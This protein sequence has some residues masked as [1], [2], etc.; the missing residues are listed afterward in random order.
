MLLAR[1][2]AWSKPKQI[3]LAAGLG[4][5]LV[6]ALVWW[7]LGEAAYL[8]LVF[9][10]PSSG[11]CERHLNRA[12]LERSLALGTRFLLAHQ[13]PAGNFDYEYDWRT[14]SLSE[15]D[16][17]VRQA[18]ALW[19]LTLL[20]QDAPKP[21]LAAGIERALAFFH[22]HS[23]LA[24]G[25]RC[26]A[27]PG[28]ES[29][30][31]GTVALVTLAHV[32][33]LRAAQELPSAHRAAL[34]QRLGEYLAMLVRAVNPSGLW[35]GDYD[36]KNCKPS[37]D[38]SPYS[39]GE[40]LLA[41][42]KAAKY[43]DHRE[44]LPVIMTSAA[45]GKQQNI[46]AAR[47]EHADSDVTKGFYQWSSMAYFELATSDFPDTRVY[48]DTLLELADWIIDTHHILSRMR[49]TGYAFEG[50]VHAYALAKQRGDARQAKLACAI[51]I[52]L[53][54]LIGW[55]VG[56]PLPNR[57][58]A[59]AGADDPKAVG[60]VQNAAFE[61]PLRIDVTQHQMHATQLARRYVY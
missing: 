52:G 25:A 1:L 10:S 54:R 14:Q 24:K 12:V 51:D 37:G 50:I 19:G 17:E 28:D 27:Y 29:G 20:Y 34:Q 7:R 16:N 22:E 2:R 5:L 32:E 31:I 39:D 59:G 55:Q 4:L 49:N 15:D 38:H 47:A 46:D 35:F 30:K 58:T 11:K 45:A 61:S 18:G 13:K 57:Y 43:L 42:V 56:G 40:A 53:E 60:G 21:E 3:A 36:V 44:L 8:R 33:Y 41:I 9:E 48:G 26:T 6:G 23:K